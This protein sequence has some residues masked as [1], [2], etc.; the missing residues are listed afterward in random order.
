MITEDE[1][2]EQ[3]LDAAQEVDHEVVDLVR[4]MDAA[5]DIYIDV[6]RSNQENDD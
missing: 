2:Y 6:K 1:A 4:R 5:W 3:W